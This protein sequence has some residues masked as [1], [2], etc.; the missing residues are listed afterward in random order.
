MSLG[1]HTRSVISATGGPPPSSFSLECSLTF[2]HGQNLPLPSVPGHE[3]SVSFPCSLPFPESPTSG[4]TQRAA[5]G[6]G[7]LPRDFWEPSRCRVCPRSGL[8]IAGQPSLSG[9]GHLG[10]FWFSTT[11]NGGMTCGFAW[12]RALQHHDEVTWCVLTLV[13]SVQNGLPTRLHHLAVPPAV[14]VGPASSPTLP[15]VRFKT[16][17]PSCVSW[18]LLEVSLRSPGNE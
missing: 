13:R 7:L 5:F 12:E 4:I 9:E 6:V 17:Q 10:C 2:L 1:G 11:A 16:T 18:E 3:S 8:L 15:V 14:R